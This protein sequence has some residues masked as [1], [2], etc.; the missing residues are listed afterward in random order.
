MK[1]KLAK[2]FVLVAVFFLTFIELAEGGRVWS[3]TFREQKP[4]RKIWAV[5]AAR[6]FLRKPSEIKWKPKKNLRKRYHELS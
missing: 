2:P 4:V 3:G 6:A 1:T 5:S